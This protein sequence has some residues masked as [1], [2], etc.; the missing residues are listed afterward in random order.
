M[1]D[2]FKYTYL[3]DV[4][5]IDK[6]IDKLWKKYLGILD[7]PRTTWEEINEARAILYFIGY[8]YPEKVAL[9]SLERRIKFNKPAISVDKFLSAI[10]GNNEKIINKYKR[11]INFQNLMK[12]YIIVKNI[13]NKVKNGSYLDEERFNKKYIKLK[14][15]EY[16]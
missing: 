13:K 15:K 4:K 9:E 3:L 6:S 10:D 8:L 5:N 14:P 1:I 16:F 7:N 11:N 12:F 2:L